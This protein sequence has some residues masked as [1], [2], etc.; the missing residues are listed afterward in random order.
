MLTRLTLIAPLL[1]IAVAATPVLAAN[2]PAPSASTL[3]QR[4][5]AD[6]PGVDQDLV[7]HVAPSTVAQPRAAAANN[8]RADEAEVEYHM[9]TLGPALPLHPRFDPLWPTRGIITTYCGGDVSGVRDI[10]PSE[11]D[12]VRQRMQAI[13]D[14]VHFDAN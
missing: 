7:A 8:V 11:L 1:L 4:A 6:D 10:T 12:S 5:I 9:A 14:S 2:A 3:L 13:L